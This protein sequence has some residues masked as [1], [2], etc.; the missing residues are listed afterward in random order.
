[1]ADGELIFGVGGRRPDRAAVVLRH[2]G[3]P[4]TA[5]RVATPRSWFGARVLACAAGAS[6]VITVLRLRHPDT[7]PAAVLAT[8]PWLVVAVIGAVALAP[9][10]AGGARPGDVVLDAVG[11]H[12]RGTG[13][14]TSLPWDDVAALHVTSF[15]RAQTVA[16][17]GRPGAG[18]T[19]WRSRWLRWIVGDTGDTVPMI[20]IP[21]LPL[22]VDPARVQHL[23]TFY[24]QTPH[25]RAELGTGASLRRLR[26]PAA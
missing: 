2:A 13:A 5:L 6:L 19:R 8:L 17:L 10:I 7:D 20:E 18:A 15:H 25:A 22:A 12:R 4:G 9:V 14:W 11:I 1:M 21:C 26:L 24:L 16:V 23:V 3:R